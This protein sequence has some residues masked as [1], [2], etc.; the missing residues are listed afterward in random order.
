VPYLIA[1]PIDC[2][3]SHKLLLRCRGLRWLSLQTTS[4]EETAECVRRMLNL[5][6]LCLSSG[7]MKLDHLACLPKLA[8]LSVGRDYGGVDNE[9]LQ[10][11]SGLTSLTLWHSRHGF[12]KGCGLH[13]KGIIGLTNLCELACGH[14]IS[15]DA[16][17]SLTKIHTLT[18]CASGTHGESLSSLPCLT[19]LSLRGCPFVSTTV[20]GSLTRLHRLSLDHFHMFPNFVLEEL[21]SLRNLQFLSISTKRPSVVQN[22]VATHWPNGL[23]THIHL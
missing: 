6:R 23:E 1:L 9:G 10:Q 12:T 13:D 22:F 16:L 4:E 19:D 17:R 5:E 14:S 2:I 21:A 3:A 15:D 20:I 18:L 8:W 7:T 11:L